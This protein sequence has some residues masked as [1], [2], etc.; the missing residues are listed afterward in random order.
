MQIKVLHFEQRQ[1]FSDVVQERLAHY[2]PG[3]SYLRVAA[4]ED[5]ASA[6]ESGTFDLVIGAEATASWDGLQALAFTQ[7][8]YP[9]TPF[10]FFTSDEVTSQLTAIEDFAAW[11]ALAFSASERLG[12]VV[13]RALAYSTLRK[14]RDGLQEDLER[15]RRLLLKS[16]KSITAG[17]LVGSITHEIN[18]P[19]EAI[20]N[21]LYLAQRNV[22][23]SDQVQ[24]CIAMAEEQ[25]GRVG[26]ITKQMLTFHRDSRTA[27]EVLVTD[28]FESL[29]S[30]F[31]TRLVQNQIQVKRQFDCPGCLVAHPGELRQALSNLMAN[32]IEAMPKGG[33][34]TL[35]VREKHGIYPRVCITVAD[36]G[37][38][39]TRD[40]I[41]HLGELFYT[42][43][44]E[45]G[46]GLGM[47][48]TR[49]LLAKYDTALN[50]YSS[51]RPGYSGTVFHLCFPE[52]HARLSQKADI[53]TFLKQQKDQIKDDHSI[54]SPQHLE[55]F[56]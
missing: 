3:L 31:A 53:A 27:Q 50:V 5:F 52:P 36:T 2:R 23:S 24:T 7:Q 35:R 9:D 44:G 8:Y 34:L 13:E 14:E 55:R 6:L 41:L 17:L 40:N 38:G 47:W 37:S 30:L 21:L 42:T 10:V 32:A 39:M 15:A 54:G 46:T 29:L 4:K 43:K 28:I 20:G 12:K 19:L 45:S 11:D 51:S 49:Q 18:N 16:Q 33:T 22:E 26:E 48:V 1:S 56:A 25:L